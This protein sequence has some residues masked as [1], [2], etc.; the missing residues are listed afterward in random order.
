MAAELG[1]VA[2]ITARRARGDI[3]R[4]TPRTPL[5]VVFDAALCGSLWLALLWGV[6]GRA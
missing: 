1:P 4:R 3:E 2:G 6:L 5:R